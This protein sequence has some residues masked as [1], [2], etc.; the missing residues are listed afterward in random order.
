VVTYG[1][2]SNEKMFR[3]QPTS[4]Q[5]NALVGASSLWLDGWWGDKKHFSVGYQF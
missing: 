2:E 3:S 5:N 4:I 1:Q